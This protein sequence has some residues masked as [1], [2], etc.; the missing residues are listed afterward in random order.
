V[1]ESLFSFLF[2]YE[3]LV[4]QQG[5]FVL[6]ASRSMW[7]AAGVAGLAAAYALWSYRQLAALRVRDRAILLTLRVALIGVALFALLRPMLLLKVAVPQQNFVGILLD[8]SRSMQIGDQDGKP[9]SDFLISQLGRSDAP[10]LTE[11]GKRFQVKVFRFSSSAER[12]QSTADLT[13]QGTGTRLGEVFDRARQE[14]SG[15]P[16]AGLVLATDGSDNSEKTL[17]D[18]LAALKAQAMP[19]FAIGIG[20]DRLTRD[21][22]I[23]RVETPRRSLKG[24]SLVLDVVVTQTGYAGAKVPLFVE[25]DGRVVSSQDIVLP[26]DGESETVKVRLKASETGPRV[27]KFRVPVQANEEV[28]QNN[29]RESLIEVYNRREKILYLE[30]QPRP[31]PKFIRRATENDDNLQVVLLWRTAEATVTV[32]D[33]YLRL[34]VDGPEELQNGF[35]QTREELFSYRGIILGSVEASAFTPEQQRMLE[36]FVDIRGGGLLALGGERSFSEGGWAGTPLAD[37]LPVVLDPGSRGPQYP[38]AELV[39]QP[40]R[41]GLTHPSTQI[42][43]SADDVAAKWKDLPMLTSLNP[44][45]E[46]KPGAN[47]LLTGKDSR[48]REQVVFAYQR[49]GRGKALVLP[50]QDT[51]LWRMH[52]KMDVKDVTHATFWQRLIRW[53]VDGVPDRVMASATPDRV[54]RGEPMTLTAEVVDPEYKGINDGRITARVT[55]PSGKVED[56]PMDWTVEHDGEYRARFTPAEDGLYKVSLGGT[57]RDGKETGRGSMTVRVAPSD[58][59]YFD[60]AMRAP[61]LQRV[62]EQTEG[63]YYAAK[64]AAAVVDAITYSGKGITVVEERE[65]WDMPVNLILLLGLMGSEWLYRRSRGLA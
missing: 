24:S 5:Q 7:L 29:Q 20:R 47:V 9:R 62:A 26:G 56:V 23:T 53:Q 58:A 1:F 33:K 30:G 14:L 38:P 36:D 21:I 10:L 3:Q 17:D 19:V 16:V 31:E 28:A 45:V 41:A 8:D 54:Q 61:L 25:D 49:Y 35:P 37:A 39:V 11:L 44:L 27:F 60:A 52:S 64:D 4:F 50:V 18:S 57:T 40:S 51:W 55:A 34:G 12:L 15:L 43:D 63:R 48:G 2:K 42:A 32:P 65:L 59:E 22:Q 46:T 6:G 13:F